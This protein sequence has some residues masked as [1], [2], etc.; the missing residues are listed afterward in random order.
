MNPTRRDALATALAVAANSGGSYLQPARGEE[1]KLTLAT[2]ETDV[3]IPLGHPCMGGGIA[4]A[5][6]VLDPLLAHGF[7]LLGAGKP[8]VFVTLDWCEVRNGAYEMFREVIA[9]AVGTEP[10]RVMLCAVHQHD[11]PV[12]DLEA[13]QLLERYKAK[14]AICDLAFLEKAVGRVAGAAK[15]CL[16]EAKPVTHLGTGEAKV[17][18]V[19]S[20]RR[21]LD[22]DGKVRYDRMSATRDPKIRDADEGTVDP[23]LKTISFWNG[24]TPL[25]ALSAYATHP[26]SYY[27]RGGVTADFV[28]IARRKRQ[29]ETKGAFQ[30][31]ASGCSGNVTAGKYND[32][33]TDNRGALA[34]RIHAAMAAVWR[35]T[36]KAPVKGASFRSVPLVLEPRSSEGFSEEALL[37]KLK[38]DPKPFGQCLAALGLSWK[39]RCDSGKPIDLPVLDFGGAAVTLLPAESYVEYQLAAQEARPNG[40]VLVAGYGECGPGYI[41]I[42]RAW[43]ENDGNLADWCWVNPG[44]EKRM[45]EAISKALE[46]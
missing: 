5:K 1:R 42:E 26:M 17:E 36:K 3:T 4:P 31:Y 9:K 10:V 37:K 34:A 41:P 15:A 45:R 28:G 46:L 24:D 27:G 39:R 40:F 8:V 13:Q 20:N 21:Y 35:A 25:C 22:A 23:L 44:S 6:E 7:V 18:K 30:M 12:A 11:A 19:A 2:F 43:K 29:G 32:G 16:K 14:G 38:D 33:S